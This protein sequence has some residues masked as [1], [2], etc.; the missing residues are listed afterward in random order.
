[1]AY[2][3][4]NNQ[5]TVTDEA[6]NARRYTY[7]AIGQMTKVEEPNPT[8]STAAVTNYTYFASGTLYQS[9]QAGQLRTFVY[10]YLGRMTTQTLPESGTTAFAYDD[11]GRLT[12]KID[13]RG[14][15]TTFTYDNLDRATGKAYSDGTPAVSFG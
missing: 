2:A 11:A 15:T 8:L 10:D 13:A 4:S 9:E 14:I 6:G 7:N 5:T 12:S 1:M 3:Y